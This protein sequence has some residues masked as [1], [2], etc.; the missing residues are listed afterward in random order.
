MEGDASVQ[1]VYGEPDPSAFLVRLFLVGIPWLV[2]CWTLYDFAGD[3]RWS[4]RQADNQVKKLLAYGFAAIVA[5]V[6]L[7]ISALLLWS[8]R[9]YL[10]PPPLIPR[11]PAIDLVTVTNAVLAVSSILLLTIP[12]ILRF[13]RWRLTEILASRRAYEALTGRPMPPPP[14]SAG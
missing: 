13:M 14:Q 6:W 10:S 2:A 5:I 11:S 3:V 8:V 1:L 7:V 12:F 9:A 4:R